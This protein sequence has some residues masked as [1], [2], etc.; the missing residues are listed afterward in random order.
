[1]LSRDH[2]G[3]LILARLLQ[4]DAPAFKDLPVDIKEKA[5]YAIKIYHKDLIKHFEDEEKALKLVIGVNS[6]LDGLIKTIFREH[7]ELHA[8]F[9]AIPAHDDIPAQLDQLGQALEIH[10]RKEERELF[11]LIEQTCNEKLM[12]AIDQSLS[13]H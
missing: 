9:K 12:D 4:K 2:H 7:Q 8:F 3:A 11:P 13:A 10:I 1:H 5:D 6:A